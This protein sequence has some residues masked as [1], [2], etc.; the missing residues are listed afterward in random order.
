MPRTIGFSVGGAKDIN[1][2]RENIRNNYLPIVTDLSYEG[3]FYDY[4]FD[5]IIINKL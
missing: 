1:D 5:T 3:L 2:F 4:F